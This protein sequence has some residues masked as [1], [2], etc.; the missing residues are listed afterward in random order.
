MGLAGIVP[1]ENQSL[2]QRVYDELKQLIMVGQFEPGQTLT[3]RALA[4]SLGTSVMPVREAL[5]RLAA[6]QAI[7]IKANRS[8]RIPQMTK[9]NFVELSE[10]R[11]RLEG[12]AA[13]MAAGN[14]SEEIMDQLE[15]DL[16]RAAQAWKNGDAE[17]LLLANLQ[18]KMRIAHNCGANFLGHLV[19]SCWLKL[20]PTYRRSLEEWSA[21]GAQ[22]SG[23]TQMHKK[24]LDAIKV[25]DSEGAQEASRNAI[26]VGQNLA[27]KFV[28]FADPDET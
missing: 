15:D 19:E 17:N 23:H 6:N 3:I 7:L 18:F 25:G 4:G 9:A 12:L 24:I 11:G 20:G 13:Q 28:D 14:L 5:Q 10:I 8:I 2:Q 27:F 22:S 21:A 1:V 26:E 16:A